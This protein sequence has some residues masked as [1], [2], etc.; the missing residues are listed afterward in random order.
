MALGPDMVELLPVPVCCGDTSA[1]LVTLEVFMQTICFTGKTCFFY[2]CHFSFF[3][4]FSLFFSSFLFI[5]CIFIRQH[6]LLLICKDT[7]NTFLFYSLYLTGNILF[8]CGFLIRTSSLYCDDS[9]LSVE[10]S[11]L[12]G[13]VRKDTRK[14]GGVEMR[15]T[16]RR[17]N[18][19]NLYLQTV[20]ENVDAFGACVKFRSKFRGKCIK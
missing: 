7:G 4:F 19:P 11:V 3:I 16:R 1:V 15:T 2:Y 17:F 9:H 13:Q 12:I 20:L 8:C 6:V 14:E 10:V 5:I 18:P